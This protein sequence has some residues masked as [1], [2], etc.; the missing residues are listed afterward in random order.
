MQ[1]VEYDLRRRAHL[2][3]EF[4]CLLAD[5]QKIFHRMDHLMR[6]ITAGCYQGDGLRSELNLAYICSVRLG[7]DDMYQTP[8]IP[9]KKACVHPMGGANTIVT[10]YDS[11]GQEQFAV[12]QHLYRHTASTWAPLV[13]KKGVFFVCVF[14]LCIMLTS[15]R[16]MLYC[17]AVYSI[18]LR[19][20]VVTCDR[21]GLFSIFLWLDYS[22]SHTVLFLRSRHSL[23]IMKEMVSNSQYDSILF[24]SVS[25]WNGRTRGIGPSLF[26][27]R[28]GVRNVSTKNGSHMFY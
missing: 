21:I 28:Q 5:D 1:S 4:F 15:S 12:R 8:E 11:C 18:P 3:S 23:H 17:R 19:P 14:T 2:I 24:G 6:P 10:I 9:T 27:S 22:L 25:R 20:S 16:R 13:I 26:K 7:Q